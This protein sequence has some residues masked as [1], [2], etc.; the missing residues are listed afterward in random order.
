MVVGSRWRR[1]VI[2]RCTLGIDRIPNTRILDKRP[3]LNTIGDLALRMSRAAPSRTRTS[4][5]PK[6]NRLGI[7]P[8]RDIASE[9]RIVHA[10][11][12]ALEQTVELGVLRCLLAVFDGET[13]WCIARLLSV[14]LGK[15]D[16]LRI[17]GELLREGDEVICGILL[18]TWSGCC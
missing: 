6:W 1:R 8:N 3:Q 7:A 12:L 9:D 10:L 4:V 13:V 18:G 2:G 14:D 16:H 17:V 15:A 11:E 5:Q